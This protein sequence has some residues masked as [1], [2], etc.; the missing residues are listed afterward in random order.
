[1]EVKK[2]RF[3][4]KLWWLRRIDQI[5][6]T[7]PGILGVM[8]NWHYILVWALSSLFFAYLLTFFK[9]GS[10]KLNLLSS[11]LGF[12]DKAW[13]LLSVFSD[14]LYN[15]TSLF[16]WFIILASILQG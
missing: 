8:L 16:G 2:R 11:D 6:M 14:L 7:G 9:D 13:V 1:M 12:G 3:N 4:I 5:K 10:L 15:F